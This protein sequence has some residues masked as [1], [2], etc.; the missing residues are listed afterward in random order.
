M[1]VELGDPG[2]EDRKVDPDVVVA[3]PDSD[4]IQE[5]DL[6]LRSV[7]ILRDELAPV[8]PRAHEV[9]ENDRDEEVLLEHP[10]PRAKDI[11]ISK[12]PS[13]EPEEHADQKH[14]EHERHV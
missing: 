3:Q 14:R 8:L 9:P 10:D 4:G 6:E 5:R 1:H 7:E 11:E 2:G 13:L 12:P